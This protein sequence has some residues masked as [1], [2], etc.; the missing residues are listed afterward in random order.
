MTV[1]GPYSLFGWKYGY[2]LTHH[3]AK[4][5]P[6]INVDIH[7]LLASGVHVEMESR[8]PSWNG[9]KYSDESS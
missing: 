2:F 3:R 8:R 9:I 1:R 7:V 5:Q 6:I 4:S